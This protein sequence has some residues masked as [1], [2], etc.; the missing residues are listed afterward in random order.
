MAGDRA[1][2]DA[3]QFSAEELRASLQE[4]EDCRYYL[5]AVN[6]PPTIGMWIAAG[7]MLY[8]SHDVAFL[9]AQVEFMKRNHYPIF[10]TDALQP[11]ILP[12]GQNCLPA[13]NAHWAAPK[14]TP[15]ILPLNDKP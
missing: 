12:Y 9:H 7:P 3:A 8:F 4:N 14:S 1:N 13:I 15:A 6:G 2:E 10:Q 5:G 11:P